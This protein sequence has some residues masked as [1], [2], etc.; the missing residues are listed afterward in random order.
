MFHKLL[1]SYEGTKNFG[2]EEIS[3]ELF[4]IYTAGL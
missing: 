1:Y 2:R 4:S 3:K